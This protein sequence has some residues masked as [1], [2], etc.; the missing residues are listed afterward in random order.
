MDQEI[1]YL[2]NDANYPVG[3]SCVRTLVFSKGLTKIGHE[4][5][6]LTWKGAND[7][8]QS[9]SGI[10]LIETYTSID[11][12]S[13]LRWIYSRLPKIYSKMKYFKP[14]VV[15]CKSAGFV[16]FLFTIMCFFLKTKLVFMITNDVYVDDRITIKLNKF[17][18]VLHLF[19]LTVVNAVFCQNSYQYRKMKKKY[20][21]KSVF[22]ITNPYFS[23]KGNK[24]NDVKKSRKYVA[25]MGIFQSQKNIPALLRIVMNNP[26][27]NFR[28]AGSEASSIDKKSQ[29]AIIKLK[30]R[31]NVKFVGY[32]TRDKI[33]TFFSDAI[34]LLN[35]SHYEG[36]SN[37]FLEAFSVGTPVISL[38]VNP[39][40]ILTKYHLG[41]IVNENEVGDKINYLIANYRNND[42]EKRIIKYLN[43][44]HN[45]E[46]LSIDLSNKL[47]SFRE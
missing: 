7:F 20:P 40:K 12:I 39:D 43:D 14:D 19:A 2:M 3:G 13:K 15:I 8:V 45:Y 46:S 9:D 33:Q 31:Q 24:D 38:I 23:F 35:T 22:R 11:R 32:L 10:E 30:G 36:F 1:P 4:I 28:I 21:Y 27:H 18:R 42:M 26:Q 5:S 44:N 25:W 29:L 47:R 41:F 6:I 16:F 37:T 17:N 34:A